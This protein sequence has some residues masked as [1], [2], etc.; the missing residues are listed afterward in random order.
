MRVYGE[1]KVWKQ[2]N[3]VGIAVAGCTVKRFIRQLGLSGVRR[4][5]VVLTTVSSA[6]APCPFDRVNRH[7]KAE[8]PNELWVSNFTYL[9][10]WQDLL[11]S[12]FVMDFFARRNM[13]WRVSSSMHTDFVSDAPEQASFDRH[14]SMVRR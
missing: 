4:D 10:A 11:C 7:L 3:R 6:N 2:L 8:Q 14:A 1:D 5:K 13:G 9:S 12:T